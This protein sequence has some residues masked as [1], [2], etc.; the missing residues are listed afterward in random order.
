MVTAGE[1]TGA[2]VVEL[3]DTW[4]SVSDSIT[5]WSRSMFTG[6]SGHSVSDDGDCAGDE[7]GAS[8]DPAGLGPGG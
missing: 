2:G 8:D 4:I 6:V 3:V 7:A 1:N 5:E